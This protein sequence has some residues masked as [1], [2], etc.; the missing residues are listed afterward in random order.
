MNQSV[1]SIRPPDHQDSLSD[2]N[3]RQAIGAAFAR[4]H[5]RERVRVLRRLLLPAG[6]M[7]LLVLAGGAFAKHARYARSPRMALRREDVARVTPDQIVELAR[8]VQQANPLALRQVVRIIARASSR[9]TAFP[10]GARIAT[11]GA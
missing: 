3:L 2:T 1:Q 6:P 11:C 9:L 7:A 5:V 10:N 8:Y 4:L